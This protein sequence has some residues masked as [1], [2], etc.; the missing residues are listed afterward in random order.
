MLDAAWATRDGSDMNFRQ[1]KFPSDDCSLTVARHSE[2]VY[3]TKGNIL[4][5]RST[6]RME[7]MDDSPLPPE[8]LVE[9]IN[10]EHWDMS[11]LSCVP[12]SFDD[13]TA[14][15]M[16]TEV[17]NEFDWI[18]STIQRYNEIKPRDP[19]SRQ[20]VVQVADRSRN[21]LSALRRK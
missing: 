15:Q 7:H 10:A 14:A 21:R 12:P 9:E 5:C 19:R 8:I 1:L 20:N 4:L 17:Y 2:D 6:I 11:E 3:W 18:L 13:E 16:L